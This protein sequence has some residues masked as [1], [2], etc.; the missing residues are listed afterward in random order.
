M[1]RLASVLTVGVFLVAFAAAFPALALTPLALHG[2]FAAPSDQTLPALPAAGTIGLA[3]LAA[4]IAVAGAFV[5]FRK[6]RG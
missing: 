4:I 6:P 1:R 3:I 2:E 5:L